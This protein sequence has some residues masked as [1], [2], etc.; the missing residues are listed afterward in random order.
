MP[1]Y[2]IIK[3]VDN[4][5]L[6]REAKQKWSAAGRDPKKLFTVYRHHNV[7][8]APHG[9]TFA[10]AVTHWEMM[11]ARWV[12]GTY[13]REYAPYVDYVSEANE[14]TSDS[15]WASPSDKA[16]AIQNVRAAATAWRDK[17]QGKTV[18]SADGGMGTIPANCKLALLAGTV[19]NT[20]PREVFEIALEFDYPIDYHA[21]TYY[22]NGVRANDD[23]PNHSGRWNRHEQEYGLKPKWLWG[24][25][26]PYA[27]TNGGWKFCLVG[28]EDKLVAAHIAWWN[29]CIQTDA[30]QRGDLIGAG[31]WFDIGG[32]DFGWPDYDLQTPQLI[33]LA[34]ALT[35]IWH[36]GTIVPTPPPAQVLNVL[37]ISHHQGKLQPNNTRTAT[38]DMGTVKNAGCSAIIIRTNYGLAKDELVDEHNRRADIAQLP[39]MFYWYPLTR[40]D[41]VRQAQ[42]AFQYS[43]GQA[44]RRGWSDIEEPT[45]SFLR[46]SEAYWKHINDGLLIADALTGLTTCIYSRQTYMDWWFTLEQ[47]K[48][49]SHRPGWWAHYANP[50]PGI[51]RIPAG[52]KDV[53]K[54]Y[55]LWQY[56][57]GNWAGVIPLVD[58][59][60]TWPWLTLNELL[61][62]SAPVS[63]SSPLIVVS[64]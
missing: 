6:L 25:S 53:I 61:G 56:G 42:L 43:G 1:D 22:P 13:L 27:N 19:A 45:P 31:C 9:L 15:T 59:D 51:P 30:Y 36:P 35:P 55:F 54:P 18:H 50:G 46:Y 16:W 40:Y 33:K 62:A 47:Q 63:T 21:Y 5:S 38:I 20:I 41:P 11:Y 23:W 64:Y 29:N 60:R 34:D 2:S 32:I 7:Y 10:Q 44:L 48:R 28:D 4:P 3:S 49:W 12:D 39:R 17:Y 57:V 14:Y 24:E 58:L 8:T 37:D 26:G 52:W